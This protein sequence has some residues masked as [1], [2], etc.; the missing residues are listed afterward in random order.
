[1]SLNLTQLSKSVGEKLGLHPSEVREVLATSFS[2]LTEAVAARE[3]VT[4]SGFGSFRVRDDG[5]IDFRSGRHL[6]NGLK[7]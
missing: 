2:E 5:S 6:K 4:I 1:V 3:P 7:H